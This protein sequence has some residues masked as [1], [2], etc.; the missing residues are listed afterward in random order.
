MSLAASVLLNK[1]ALGGSWTVASRSGGGQVVC[2]NAATPNESDLT[3]TGSASGPLFTRRPEQAI[4]Q[5]TRVFATSVQTDSAWAGL[6][7]PK[8]II[9]ME[10]EVETCR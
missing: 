10:Q 5:S 2:D 1:S 3:E 4:T 7:P 9:C 8:L 6:A